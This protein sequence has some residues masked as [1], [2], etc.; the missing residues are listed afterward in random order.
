MPTS[1]KRKELLEGI[2]QNTEV[3][4]YG[5]NKKIG[6]RSVKIKELNTWNKYTLIL[7]RRKV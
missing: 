7:I 4:Q 6:K 2:N 1:E 3:K 5:K